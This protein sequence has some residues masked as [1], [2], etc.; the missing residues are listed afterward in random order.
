M[1]TDTQDITIKLATGRSSYLYGP[2]RLAH[3]FAAASILQHATPTIAGL[4]YESPWV[5][6]PTALEAFSPPQVGRSA[7]F[8]F[9]PP[10]GEDFDR[11]V[12]RRQVNRRRIGGEQRCGGYMATVGVDR[13]RVST[14]WSGV[15]QGSWMLSNQPALSSLVSPLQFSRAL[16]R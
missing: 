6:T 15:V 16:S 14:W 3:I 4:E 12:R 10:K 7:F 1:T 11:S 2:V 9:F 5:T 8:F 13:R